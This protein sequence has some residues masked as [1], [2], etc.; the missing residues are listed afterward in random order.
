[1]FW[2]IRSL[3]LTGSSGS[4]R[5]LVVKTC[6]PERIVVSAGECIR[7]LLGQSSQRFRKVQSS[8]QRSCGP[9]EKRKFSC[10]Y[11]KLRFGRIDDAT[12]RPRHP[13]QCV[14]LSLVCAE[15][16]VRLIW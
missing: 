15:N 4:R 6:S 14:L 11:R 3:W 10:V 5:L 16:L 1:M 8:Q 2:S 7:R 12:H 9:N 13:T